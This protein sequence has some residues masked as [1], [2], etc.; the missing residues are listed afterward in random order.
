MSTITVQVIPGGVRSTQITALQ[1]RG[2]AIVQIPALQGPPGVGG[3]TRAEADQLY[4]PI[5]TG[6]GGATGYELTFTQSELSI[7][8]LLPVVH[9]LASSPSAIAVYDQSGEALEPDGWRVLNGTT[10]ELSLFSFIPISGVWRL[11]II[12]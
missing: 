3:L 11:S 7:A 12:R 2:A 5:G 8:G 4:A 1:G 10:I 9:G 6:P